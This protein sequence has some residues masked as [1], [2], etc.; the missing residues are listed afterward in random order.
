MTQNFAQTTIYQLFPRAFT[1][2]GTLAAASAHLA[3]IASLGVDYVY[4]CPVFLSDDGMDK[5]YWSER[6]IASGFE[7]PKNPYRM[8]DY[9][10]VDPEYGTKEDL[11]N[12]VKR[13]HELGLK[14]LFDLVYYHCGPNAVF[15][16]EHPDFI[17]RTPDGSPFTGE[18]AFPR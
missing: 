17:Q 15:L 7:N 1:R 10:A 13:A 9:F 6:Q 5:T 3:D 18:W 2:E 16:K 8:K 14:V 11:I 4:L 12:F